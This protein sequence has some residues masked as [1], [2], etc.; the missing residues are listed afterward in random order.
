[1]R[2]RGVALVTALFVV[3]IAASL[4]THL[5]WR[6]SLWIGQVESLRDLAQT[7]LLA[8]AAMEWACA[9][10]ADDAANSAVD[11]P[12]EP[13][14]RQIPPMEAEGGSVG[15]Q[16]FDEQA[17]WNLN[18]LLTSEGKIKE[19]ELDIYRRLLAVLNL[20]AS[21]AD[22]LADWMDSDGEVRAAGAEDAHYLARAPST[23]TR[24]GPLAVLEDVLA[25]KGYDYAALERLR[26]YVTALP[27]RTS[28]NV[29][30]TTAA[31]LEAVL[32]GI[33]TGDAERLVLDGQRLPFKD[34]SDFRSRM[35]KDFPAEG[36]ANVVTRSRYF[37]LNL[38]ASHGKGG[39]EMHALIDRGRGW[40]VV[41]WKRFG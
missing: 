14:A 4:A 38:T 40:P 28:V 27:E 9:V 8:A 1:M 31:V 3:A 26:P 17:R 20:P 36:A 16:L 15:G 37:S 12:Q 39:V 41:L 10:L 2:A 32:P 35:G 24:G 19:S 6:S 13:W 33:S 18:N 11:H 5:I 30:S 7:R 34:A 25:V 21:L 29:N 23:R 22:T